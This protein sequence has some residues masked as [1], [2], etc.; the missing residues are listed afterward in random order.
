[1]VNSTLFLCYSL[2]KR[3][4][5]LVKSIK[6]PG[7]Y[8]TIFLEY[9]RVEK[10]LAHNTVCAYQA[11]L[12]H[13]LKTEEITLD[14]LK[15]HIQTLYDQGLNKR[16]IARH[17][18]SIRQFF[19][20]LF[21][22]D[23]EQFDLGKDLKSP[24]IGVSLPRILTLDEVAKLLEIAGQDSTFH[25]KRTVVFLEILYA[26]GLRISELL[27]LK[28][29]VFKGG[30]MIQ[31]VGKGDKER[32]IPLH[33]ELL[34][35]VQDFIKISP[36]SPWLF[37][38]SRTHNK[39][40]TRQRIFQLLKELGAL[41][42]IAPERLSPHVLRHSFATHFLERGMDLAV[43]QKLLGHSD[44]GTTQIYTHISPK[45]L[46]KTLLEKHPFGGDN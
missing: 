39:P 22:Q 2:N 7:Q 38:S 17:I 18:S 31:I 36:D 15:T 25:G 33:P 16:S 8:L 42:D 27:S 13:L 32:R 1:M 3:R 30:Q 19:K 26:T 29:S 45:H 23:I 44:I 41:S 37:P 14:L 10:G 12:E 24:K 20:F 11:D 6:N 35:I 4:E 5:I 43:L 34:T 28:R 9:L 40:L 46:Q 21:L